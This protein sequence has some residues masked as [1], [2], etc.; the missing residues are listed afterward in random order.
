[1]AVVVIPAA[2]LIVLLAYSIYTSALADIEVSQATAVRGRAASFRSWLDAAGRSLANEA[3]AARY[4]G[5]DKCHNLAETFLRRNS[6]FASVSFVDESSAPCAAGLPIDASRLPDSAPD[7][8]A[9][10]YRLLLVGGQIWIVAVDPGGTSANRT[11]CVLVVDGAALRDRLLKVGTLGEANVALSGPASEIVAVDAS[12]A[13]PE[14]A[15]AQFPAKE[16]VWRALDR[17]GNAATFAWAAIEGSSLGLLMRFDDRRLAI[18]QHRLAILCLTQLAMLGL[19]ALVYV[20]AIRRD[21]VQWIQGIETAARAR[22]RDPEGGARA[23]VTPSMPRELRSVAES[24]NAMT[25]HALERAHALRASL[26]ENRALMLEMHHRIKNSLQVIQSYLALIRR[27]AAKPEAALLARI[28]ARVGVLAVAYRLALTPNGIRPIAAKPFLEE[29]CA[30]AIGGLRKPRQRVAYAIEW[31]GEL[32]VDRAIPLGLGLVE[33]LIAAFG[34]FDVSYIGVRLAADEDGAMELRVESDAL[35]AEADLP[36]KVMRGL[37]NQLG[38][39]AIPGGGGEI[40]RWRF[41]P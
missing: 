5:T 29:I 26:S 24:F 32:A 12:S 34:A 37:A 30:T 31:S 14:W 22:D 36:Q 17:A 40:L 35:P 19:L 27:S 6:G 7:G 21:V 1:M 18:A 25:D 9:A 38:A 8:E 15:P 23:P 10:D 13:Q 28:E 3:F 16:P 41:H 39:E 20:A 33:A 11:L 2:A 4:V